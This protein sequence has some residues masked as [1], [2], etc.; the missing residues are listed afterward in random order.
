MVRNVPRDHYLHI[1][2]VEVEPDSNLEDEDCDVEPETR[3][4]SDSNSKE[5]EPETRIESNSNFEDEEYEVEDESSTDQ[6]K[7][8]DSENELTSSEDEI[9]N[10]NVGLGSDEVEV[11]S[12]NESGQSDSLHSVDDSDSEGGI[13]KARFPEF[14]RNSDLSNPRLKAGLIFASKKILKEAIK[15]YN[16]KNRYCV[17]LKRNDNKRIQV[18]YKGECPWMLWAA[19]VNDEDPATGSW[20]IR[21]VNS[22]HTCLREF[23]NHNVTAKWL[24]E[25]YFSS[26]YVDHNFS[27][28][29]LKQAV[30]KDWGIHV[31][32]TKCIRTKNLAIE[33]LNGNHKEQYAKL[34]AYLDELRQSNPGTST[35]CKLDERKFE[36]LY[37]CMQAMKDG[38]KAGCRPIIGLD[39]CHLKGYYQGH[40]LAAVG[41]DADDSIYPISFAVIES[42]NQSSWCWF[43]ELLATDLEIENSHSFT[44]MTDRQ[45]GLM[46]AVPELFPYSAHRTCDRHLYSNAKT[47]GVFI[48]KALKDQLWKAARA[49]YVTQFQSAM[50]EL[51]VSCGPS[52]QHSVNIQEWTCSCRKWQLTVPVRG[53]QQWATN[54]T[55][56]LI[57][58]PIFRRP[59]GRP[60][61]KRKREADE[62]PP[63]IGKVSKRGIRIFCKKCGGSGHNI[64]TCKG[65]V[66]ANPKRPGQTSSSAATK[67]PRIPKLPLRR[68]GPRTTPTSQ[69]KTTQTPSS[70]ST[71]P[72]QSNVFRWMPTPTV[73]TSQESSVSHSSPSPTPIPTQPSYPNVFIWMPTPGVP[74]SQDN[75]GSHLSPSSSPSPT[76]IPTPKPLSQDNCGSQSSPRIDL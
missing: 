22:E 39:G 4:E 58:P 13:K 18:K 25:N 76:P 67:T 57:L 40:L 12:E 75:C 42:E 63:M 1:Y 41:I 33:N 64:R 56:K 15:M 66:D 3:I 36:S 37:I 59:P 27:H 43:L 9:F 48:G 31:P 24:A 62:A 20:Q 29:S 45:K 69:A 14:N 34:Y 10:V 70:T 38:F 52:S 54:D 73:R 65:K 6:S 5:V 53:E 71:E 35:I 50:D 51:K 44:F 11:E 30:H 47:S 16:I 23:Q 60:H 8:S 28:N 19:P 2:I 61:K 68:P 55:M 32:K 74:L 49:T 17:K 46:D 72:T 21:S 7:F 26:F